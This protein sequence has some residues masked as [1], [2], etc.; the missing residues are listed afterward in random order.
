MFSSSY[1]IQCNYGYTPQVMDCSLE[2]FLSPR[3]KEYTRLASDYPRTEV[4]AAMKEARGLDREEL[5]VSL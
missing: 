1:N 5:R 4:E 3:I 2:Q